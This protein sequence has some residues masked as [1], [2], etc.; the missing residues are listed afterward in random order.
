MKV[1]NPGAN[2]VFVGDVF[3][4]LKNDRVSGVSIPAGGI[5]FINDADAMKSP[6]L[7]RLLVNGNLSVIPDTLQ[8]GAAHVGFIA[9]SGTGDVAGTT[10]TLVDL[11]KSFTTGN[12]PVAVG[13]TI[14]LATGTGDAAN[15]G[16]IRA[17]TVVA[18]TTLTVAPAFPAVTDNNTYQVIKVGSSV[19]NLFSPV[20]TVREKNHILTAG[21]ATTITFETPLSSAAFG[22][23][24]TPNYSTAFWVSTKTTTGFV[25][26]V[27]TGANGTTDAVDY[28]VYF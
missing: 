21:A 28:E 16:Q 7:N 9:F 19:N 20:A 13:D 27:G 4:S 1:R 5:K 8:D 10:T 25:I 22:V 14:K 2:T 12:T 23:V 6:E 17:V 11:T 3:E 15:D 26:N 18:A 24:L